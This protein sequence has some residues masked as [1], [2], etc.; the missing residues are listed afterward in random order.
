MRF[1]FRSIF[2]LFSLM[3]AYPGAT[4]DIIVK[5]N[6]A[7]I[8]AK[9]LEITADSVIFKNRN[10]DG[11]PVFSLPREEVKLVEYWNG[12]KEYFQ[13]SYSNISE[14][15]TAVITGVRSDKN[16]VVVAGISFHVER[17]FTEY[18]LILDYSDHPD[19][20]FII[21]K[22]K[23]EFEF[24][25][26]R[27]NFFT[28]YYPTG[29]KTAFAKFVFSDEGENKR[30]GRLSN[31]LLEGLAIYYDDSVSQIRLDSLQSREMREMFAGKDIRYR[32]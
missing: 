20:N 10:V 31:N 6:G 12:D 16:E 5:N 7:Q 28:R 21:N 1:L 27:E 26:S 19:T 32:P 17:L 14:T 29:E 11:S 9:V 30:F 23:I 2:I 22:G 25:V 4:Q 18:H 3:I 24:R 15:D 13:G 8:N